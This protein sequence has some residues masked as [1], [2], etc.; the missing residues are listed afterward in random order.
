MTDRLG[1]APVSGRG[2]TGRRTFL[3]Q[4]A[5]Q[6][7]G[8]VPGSL[9]A[10]DWLLQNSYSAPFWASDRFL[11]SSPAERQKR[12]VIPASFFLFFCPSSLLIH[13]NKSNQ[14]RETPTSS[15]FYEAF[16][17]RRLQKYRPLLATLNTARLLTF[18]IRPQKRTQRKD[19]GN[20]EFI[21]H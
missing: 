18:S 12:K 10:D 11:W 2:R 6:V 7:V 3:Q 8:P 14:M 21:W 16:T 19:G 13:D 20:S 17:K 1:S 9:Q 5:G 4:G 15:G